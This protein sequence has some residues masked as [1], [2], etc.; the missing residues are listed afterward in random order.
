MLQQSDAPAAAGT[1]QRESLKA[2]SRL[3]CPYPAVTLIRMFR[4]LE[5]AGLSGTIRKVLLLANGRREIVP[6]GRPPRHPLLPAR[7]RVPVHEPVSHDRPPGE[8]HSDISR[9]EAASLQAGDWVEVKDEQ[10]IMATL[11]DRCSLRGLVFLPEMLPYCGRRFTVLKRVERIFLEESRQLRKIRATVLLDGVM[12]GGEM[13]G[14]DKSCFF[15]WR[16]DWL[17]RVQ[18]PPAPAG[19]APTE[20]A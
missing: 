17:R 9:G 8:S 20:I 6:C 13:L 14:C 2:A 18:V 7:S 11:D 3:L 19:E 15:Y 5:Y 4:Y 16:E 1:C 10:E 12:C